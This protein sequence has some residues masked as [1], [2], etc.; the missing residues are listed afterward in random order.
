MQPK[1]VAFAMDVFRT[2]RKKQAKWHPNKI[3]A[4]IIRFLLIGVKVSD[5]FTKLN[6]H[7]IP[8]AINIR[9][10]AKTKAGTVATCR[11]TNED[12]LTEI[13]AINKMSPR[14]TLK[15]LLRKIV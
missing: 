13:S 2:P 7:R 6:P 1:R 10:N 12:V 5:V 15:D 4:I 3:P 14:R 11:T 8:L 9:Q